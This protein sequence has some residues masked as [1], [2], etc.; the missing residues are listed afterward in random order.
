MFGRL[1][2]LWLIMGCFLQGAAQQ[3]DHFIY[4][5]SDNK[6]PFYV[7]VGSSTSVLNSSSSGYLIL[8]KISMGAVSLVIGFPDNSYPEQHFVCTIPGD[9]DK[10][11]LLKRFPDKGWALY[12]LQE[13][14]IIYAGHPA[15]G[16]DSTQAT[17]AQAPAAPVTPP[18]AA[19]T[20]APVSA[21]LSADTPAASVSA[22]TP[23][24][25]APTP[26]SV[27]STPTSVPSAP[28]SV[29]SAQAD[30][31]VTGT[32]VPATSDPAGSAK[33]SPESK[34]AFGD[35][36]VAVTND[37]TLKNLKTTPRT[38]AVKVAPV[39]APVTGRHAPDS[40][41]IALVSSQTTENGIQLVYTDR[42]ASG[43]VDTVQVLLSGAAQKTDSA[44]TVPDTTQVA[45]APIVTTPASTA[46]T[47][48]ATGSD[49]TARDTTQAFNPATLVKSDKSKDT[50]N[51]VVPV[52]KQGAGQTPTSTDTSLAAGFGVRPTATSTTS[53]ASTSTTSASTT[54][55]VNTDCKRIAGDEDF[56][57][58]RKKL[59]TEN[60]VDRM[61]EVAHKT[62]KKTCFTTEQIRGLSLLFLQEDDRYK[63]LEDAYPFAS[64]SGNF[65]S[66]QSLFS[67]VYFINR[68]KAL[69]QR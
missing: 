16:G 36:L 69:V 27:T 24:S 46:A 64:D 48:S 68:F 34:D 40:T 25:V 26:T 1:I 47:I 57:R 42:Q 49:T 9:K 10:G 8:P 61:I 55:L 60:D 11:Y 29:P 2:G 31:P 4:I 41:A 54:G 53:T 50:S 63:F 19:P 20:G 37:P 39:S 33:T 58:L 15:S 43:N 14:T 66:L 28:A 59:A 18:I 23:V 35:I 67:S 12:D 38:P 5:Q 3:N 45:A 7:K 17:P 65:K 56:L 22:S 21:T 52:F 13:L 32:P 30:T 6:L 51:Y 62:F 44:S